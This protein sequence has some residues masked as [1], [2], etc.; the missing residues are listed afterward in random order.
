MKEDD[1]IS[2]YYYHGVSHHLG[3]DTHDPSDRNLPLE[4]GNVITVEPGLY[5]AEYGI[6]VR[7]E[8]NVLVTDVG[9]ENLSLEIPKEL[10]DIYHG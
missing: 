7:I 2:K 3:L 5:F 1:D 10:K 9:G 8:D 6:G 4:R